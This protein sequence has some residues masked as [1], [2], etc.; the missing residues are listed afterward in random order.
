MSYRRKTDIYSKVDRLRDSRRQIIS[1][2][3]L[4]YEVRRLID[5]LK[6]NKL[7][8]ELMSD[9]DLVVLYRRKEIMYLDYGSNFD[10]QYLGVYYDYR[11]ASS[12]KLKGKYN[13]RHM[14]MLVLEYKTLQDVASDV[15]EYV[16]STY[17]AYTPVKTRM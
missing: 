16:S 9:N 12:M 17:V 14:N 10:R 6:S 8:V 3:P 4:K 2:K 15:I 13:T 1:R 7:Q 5:F 11:V